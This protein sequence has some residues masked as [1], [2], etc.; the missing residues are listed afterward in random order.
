MSKYIN[1]RNNY[2]KIEPFDWWLDIE[3]NPDFAIWESEFFH[4]NKHYK[5][6]HKKKGNKK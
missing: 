3:M 4:T 1:D 6:S 2:E 5:N